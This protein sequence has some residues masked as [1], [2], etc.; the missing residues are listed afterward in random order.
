MLGCDV[1]G[2]EVSAPAVNRKLPAKF[3]SGLVDLGVLDDEAVRWVA[4]RK[5]HIGGAVLAAKAKALAEQAP[6]PEP[7]GSQPEDAEPV[8]ED[9]DDDRRRQAEESDLE[10]LEV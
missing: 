3:E 2:C 8:R 4:C 5:T 7:A 10:A 6:A 1:D 9:E